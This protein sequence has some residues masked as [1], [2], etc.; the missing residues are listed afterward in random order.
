MTK[1]HLVSGQRWRYTHQAAPS[2]CITGFEDAIHGTYYLIETRFGDGPIVRTKHRFREFLALHELLAPGTPFPV[3][4]VLLRTTA[5]K[6]ARVVQLE[7]YLSEAVHRC[8][9]AWAGR[10]SQG[11]ADADSDVLND[12]LHDFLAARDIDRS[13][14]ESRRSSEVGPMPSQAA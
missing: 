8:V 1:Q 9:Q 4:K 6:R 12:P 10:V 13:R 2:V 14:L 11:D 7:K 5:V 3:E